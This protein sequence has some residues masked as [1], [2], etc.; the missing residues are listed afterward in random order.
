MGE[1]K[2]VNIDLFKVMLENYGIIDDYMDSINPVT[3]DMYDK[4]KDL[5]H[6]PWENYPELLY[7]KVFNQSV[8]GGPRMYKKV[9][10]PKLEYLNRP[11]LN[12]DLTNQDN[13]IRKS[14]EQ[15]FLYVQVKWLCCFA[16]LFYLDYVHDFYV[17]I[18]NRTPENEQTHNEMYSFL[19]DYLSKI[20]TGILN[21][22]LD[23]F[24]RDIFIHPDG[25]HIYLNAT[26]SRINCEQVIYNTLFDTTN[27]YFGNHTKYT[28]TLEVVSEYCVRIMGI[29]KI[30]FRKFQSTVFNS[31]R[32]QYYGYLI[33]YI[34]Y[35]NRINP[36]YIPTIDPRTLEQNI[37]SNNFDY[38]VSVDSL[39]G[40][41]GW[42]EATQPILDAFTNGN[43]VRYF[44]STIDLIDASVANNSIKNAINNLNGNTVS[45][46]LNR[47]RFNLFF[48]FTNNKQES[49]INYDI[50]IN[51]IIINK[52][53]NIVN[54]QTFYYKQG[55]QGTQIIQLIQILKNDI[56]N[57]VIDNNGYPGVY[58]CTQSCFK[59]LLDF[60]KTI[61]FFDIINKLHQPQIMI[62]DL[63]HLMFYNDILAADKSSLFIKGTCLAEVE[64]N[65]VPQLGER[66]YRLFLRNHQIIKIVDDNIFIQDTLNNNIIPASIHGNRR[67]AQVTIPKPY[68][69][70]P[71]NIVG[72][73]EKKRCI[74]KSEKKFLK[75]L[76]K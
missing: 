74:N 71:T 11:F 57:D 24:L 44:D 6:K 29:N 19:I 30:E 67:T 75:S 36:S 73:G 41:V 17:K 58:K 8:R 21:M 7:K 40:N 49:V 33:S 15:N 31:N 48:T 70:T 47:T 16:I 45:L 54:N 72:F 1:P 50:D 34:N 32:T 62:V 14:A 59:T 13:D 9:G 52:Y 69:N 39:S 38:I 37:Y 26:G 25:M 10:E 4:I 55:N 63:H 51:Q 12:F 68:I 5:W 2:I 27:N 3:Q 46:N 35:C 18:R 53:F 56:L 23:T 64:E 22:D 20:T 61:Q 42:N 60:A 66:P 65:I 28:N 76:L 43:N